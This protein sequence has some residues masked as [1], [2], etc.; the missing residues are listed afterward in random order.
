VKVQ[1]VDPAHTVF[2]TAPDMDAKAFRD[3]ATALRAA[4]TAHRERTGAATPNVVMLPPGV[5][6]EVVKQNA[7]ELVHVAKFL[8]ENEVKPMQVRMPFA[9]QTRI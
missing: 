2:V 1:A 5:T 9:P 3:Y 4:F 8:A 7:E 6:M